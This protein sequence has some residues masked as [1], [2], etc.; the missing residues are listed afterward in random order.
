MQRSNAPLNSVC[1]DSSALAKTVFALSQRFTLIEFM[2]FCAVIE[3]MV[4]RDNVILI[5]GIN[6][7][8]ASML[9]NVNPW[10]QSGAFLQPDH[11]INPFPVPRIGTNFYHS[12]CDV[13]NTERT[14][15]ED[16][17][18]EVARL[19][20]AQEFFQ[21][22]AMPLT[23]NY[24]SHDQIVR[25]DVNQMAFDFVSIYNR[26]ANHVHELKLFVNKH[27]PQFVQ[28]N[29]PPI[30]IEILKEAK[31]FHDLVKLALEYR[32]KY[33]KL[34][35]EMSYLE[36]LLRDTEIAPNTKNKEFKKWLNSWNKN[37]KENR[38][39]S[40]L[41]ANGTAGL[42]Y[43]GVCA[44]ASIQAGDVAGSLGA[45]AK[46]IGRLGDIV[47]YMNGNRTDLILHPIRSAFVNSLKT[48]QPDIKII[49]ERLFNYNPNSFDELMKVSFLGGNNTLENLVDHE[50]KVRL[51]R[52]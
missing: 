13:A 20:A 19:L 3:Q 8:Q 39:S 45:G 51:S 2:D 37:L 49:V 16:S 28:I 26:Q 27:V 48:S 52:I 18:F 1:I 4:L 33:F 23:R 24:L 6:N 32:D 7:A 30:A 41:L 42:V 21:R 44:T 10:L 43:D 35:K 11:Q 17:R 25:P 36:E 29:F 38:E 9:T 34:R 47:S 12:H 14:G 50:M 5:G 46:I 15:A 31:S 22:P 40:F